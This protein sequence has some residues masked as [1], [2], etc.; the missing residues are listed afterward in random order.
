MRMPMRWAS[1][2]PPAS[3][4]AA[5]LGL[6]RALIMTVTAYPEPRKAGLGTIVA[7]RDDRRL[8]PGHYDAC[9]RADQR[10]Q[11]SRFDSRVHRYYITSTH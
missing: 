10:E 2:W 5:L 6:S 1:C 3:R 4:R 8:K 7:C 9:R 11:G